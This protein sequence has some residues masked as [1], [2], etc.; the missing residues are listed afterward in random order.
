MS[1]ESVDRP[2]SG[3]GRWRPVES[4]WAFRSGFLSIRRDRCRLPDGR[5]SPDMYFM[6]LRDFAMTVAVTAGGTV[7][8]S[9]EYKHGSGDVAYTLP[10]GFIEAGEAPVAAARREL[11]EETGYDGATFDP[12]GAYLVFPSLS[13]ARGYFFLARGVEH[14]ADPEPDEFEEIE[15]VPVAVDELRQDLLASAPRYVTDVSSALALG[16]ALSRLNGGR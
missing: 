1:S 8:L 16:L 15:V 10:A 11:R 6:E 4:T 13:G 12:L 9:R 14:V 2:T 3:V 7:L 5:L